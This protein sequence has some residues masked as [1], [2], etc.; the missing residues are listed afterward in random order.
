MGKKKREHSPSLKSL[1]ATLKEIQ[2]HIDKKLKKDESNQGEEE[3]VNMLYD[4]SDEESQDGDNNVSSDDEGNKENKSTE[5]IENSDELA[6]EFVELDSETLQILSEEEDSDKDSLKREKKTALLDKYPRSGNCPFQ[7]PKLNLEIEASIKEATMKRDKFFSADLDL[8]G[9]SL[10]ALGSGINMIFNG[11][12]Q[13]IDTKE[14]LTKLS[15]ADKIGQSSREVGI[16]NKTASS[17]KETSISSINIF[18]LARPAGSRPR[19]GRHETQ[20]PQKLRPVRE[21]REFSS[22]EPFT[23]QPNTAEHTCSTQYQ[24]IETVRY[25]AGR[26]GRFVNAWSKLTNDSFILQC[27]SGYKI[28]FNTIPVQRKIPSRNC[29]N[30]N[31]EQFLKE[32]IANLL[33]LGAITKV[34]KTKNQFVST[35]FLAPKANG[36]MRFILNLKNLN[37]FIPT[38]HFKMEDFRTAT[39]LVFK[40][41][42]LGS[43]DLK[44]AYFL[45]P[46][47]KSSRKYV[48]FEW[49]GNRYEWNCI[50]FGLNVAPWLYTKIMKPVVNF[51][52]NK[53]LSSV[54]YLD[55]WLIFGNTYD[56]CLKKLVLTIG[57]LE[58]LGFIVNR[59]KSSLIPKNSCQFLG[60]VLTSS[61]MTIELPETKR[62]Q[63]VKLI[64]NLRSKQVCSIRE[65]ASLVGCII[66]ACPAIQYGWLYTK[67]LERLKYLKL[68]KNYLNYSAKMVIPRSLSVDL[69]WW[70]NKI[71]FSKNKIRSNRFE[72]EIFSDASSLGW[73]IASN[74]EVAFGLWNDD[75]KLNHINYLEL[76]AAFIG[77]KNF[78]SIKRHCE[79][80]LRI[81]NTTAISYIN[82]MGGIQYPILNKITRQIWQFCE[83]RNLWVFAS[84]IASKDNVEADTASRANNVDT[85]WELANW[86]FDKITD[87]FGKVE[88][89]LFASSLNRKCDRYCSWHPESEAYCIDAFTIDWS[90]WKFFA[91]PPMALILKCLQKIKNDQA[92]GILI[93]PVW[94]SQPWYPLWSTMIVGEPIFFQPDNNLLLS[95]CRTIQHPLASKLRLM[96]G[97]LSGMLIKGKD[98]KTEPLKINSVISWLCDRYSNGASFGTINTCRAALSL[99]LGDKVGKNHIISRL[100]KGIYNNKPAKPRYD[101]IYDLDPILLALE[102]L[103]PLERLSLPELTDKLIM[104]FALVTAHR[105]QTLSFILISNIIETTRGYEIE[106]P[107]KV[108]NSKRGAFQP[109]LILPKFTGKPELCIVNTLNRY[110]EVTKDLREQ[111]DSLFITTKK[112][113]RKASKDT[114]SRWIRAFLGKCGIGR[115]FAPHSLRHAVT[116]SALKKG[117]DISVI[118]RLAGW[119]ERS[120]VF[121]RFYNRPIVSDDNTFAE[122]TLTKLMYGNKL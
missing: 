26:L 62:H 64:R 15:D 93:A 17:R 103:Y 98:L 112:P 37:K 106:I 97:L 54:V 96:A 77:L 8:C 18:K 48:C 42:F 92:E 73:G 75:E 20:L 21:P 6:D 38:E 59:E 16:I 53:G 85:E 81:D 120:N 121:N 102:K 118:K 28:H 122:A 47:H 105:K 110:L 95:P 58:S 51:L 86:A 13:E 4:A 71:L 11:S 84:Y 80:L 35:Y 52:R 43:I 44:D 107:Q 116:S 60:M 40:D 67:S 83:V 63:I 76:L 41:C 109:L 14:L 65:F 1:K 70:E 114:I 119:S 100:L 90:A 88:I 50:P 61:E 2:G 69:D 66:A 115:E 49:R 79:L 33:T 5:I 78:A 56:D 9:A 89:D 101:R 94:P 117:I 36:K 29:L 24:E 34:P 111:C 7:T 55:D 57:V 3:L 113:Y 72:L 23:E 27:L 22:V 99:I 108:K 74:G 25:I 12:T 19:Q 32:A 10:V 45:I 68:L 104:L 31:D 82:R 46:L 30:K 91:F 87:K 39:K